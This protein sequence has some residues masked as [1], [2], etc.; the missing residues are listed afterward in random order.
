MYP[1]KRIV[2]IFVSGLF[3]FAAAVAHG[4]DGGIGTVGD[5]FQIANGAQ[6][7]DLRTTSADWDKHFILTADINLVGV[8]GGAIGNSTTKFTGTFD[9]NGHTLDGSSIVISLGS[10]TSNY[11]LFGW[12]NDPDAEIRDLGVIGL[13]INAGA[14]S[15]NIGI[16]VGQLESGTVSGCY[17]EGFLGGGSAYLGGLIG[18]NLGT[19]SDCYSTTPVTGGTAFFVGGLVGKNDSGLISDSHATG[20]VSGGGSIGGLL[21]L[22]FT[23]SQVDNCY[24]TG[25]VS[26]SGQLG[27]L[28]GQQCTNGTV[29]NCHATGEV[30]GTSVE[31]GGL[32]GLSCSGSAISFS[33]AT[34][35][36]TTAMWQAG[37]LVGKNSTGSTITSC[38][39]RGAAIGTSELGGLVG[40]LRDTGSSISKCYSDGN[41]GLVG[42]ASAGVSVTDSFWDSQNGGA[43][44]SGGTGK[45]TTQMRMQATFTN[46]WTMIEGITTPFFLILVGDLNDDGIV[47]AL[48][49]AF[50]AAN[51]MN[52]N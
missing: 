51:W 37:G 41:A 39:A 10:S 46:T 5:P 24:A 48:D 27:G 47:N 38:Y 11:G 49:L 50:L 36:A 20:D 40:T 13:T 34:G 19:I 29:S 16:L 22:G 18:L 8:A 2:T 43:G 52:E 33:Y 6:L 45:T 12:V 14:S 28:V 3:L 44:S 42:T 15:T 9:G 1:E 31:I 7:G 30:S 21:G 25:D 26:G 4:Y 17:S 35:T 23:N 32:V